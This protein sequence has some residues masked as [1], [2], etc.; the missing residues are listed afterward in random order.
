M[1]FDGTWNYTWDYRN[2]LASSTNRTTTSS[3]RYDSDNQRVK[4]TEGADTTIYPRTDYEIKNGTPKLYLSLGDTTVATKENG[5]ITH[6]H[7]DHLGGTNITTDSTGAITQILDYYPFGET[8]IG[9]YNIK[10]KK[11]ESHQG[12]NFFIISANKKPLKNKGFESLRYCGVL[13]ESKGFEPL[14]PLTVCRVSSAVLSTTQPT[15]RNRLNFI[16]EWSKE[17]FVRFALFTFVHNEQSLCD[18]LR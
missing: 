9:E 16:E 7:T 17:T 11:F 15:L 10:I 1:S 4:L 3:Y 6:L 13:A 18:H 2:R 8:I 12:S 14:K 5:D